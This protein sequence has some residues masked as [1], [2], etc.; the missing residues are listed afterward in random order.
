MK[1]IITT[2]LLSLAL[3][4]SAQSQTALKSWWSL[5]YCTSYSNQNVRAFDSLIGTNGA[6]YFVW[7]KIANN[8][9]IAD[10]PGIQIKP[11]GTTKGYWKRSYDG[12][13]HLDWMG[14]SNSSTQLTWTQLGYR[15]SKLDSMY[16]GFSPFYIDST[17]RPD[18]TALILAYSAMETSGYNFMEMSPR[19]YYI[20]KDISSSRTLGGSGLADK[21]QFGIAGKC[22]VVHLKTNEACFLDRVPGSQSIA[23]DQW[24]GAA[25]IISDLI[26]DGGGFNTT[27][28]RLGATSNSMIS[29]VTFKNCY[30]GLDARFCLQMQTFQTEGNNCAYIDMLFS[31]GNWPD[32]SRSNSQSNRVRVNGHRTFG[33][34]GWCGVLFQ[35]GSNCSVVDMVIE[36]GG[37][38]WGVL[39]DCRAGGGSSI[40]KE[41]LVDNIYGEGDYDSAAV[42]IMNGDG[43]YTV[44]R[45]FVRGT[46]NIVWAEDPANQYP[47]INL[48]EVV[49]FDNTMNLVQIGNGWCWDVRNFNYAGTNTQTDFCCNN[50]I[51]N[52]GPGGSQ[53]PPAARVRIAPK[54]IN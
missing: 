31:Y 2:L 28:I 48:Y 9:G 11:R 34:G 37:A 35:Q 49:W 22:A 52:T 17:F 42:G 39:F 1:K 10:I 6:G 54:I 19:N 51:F 4:F 44:Q 41:F 43:V 30:I 24:I 32:A 26:I 29:N 8:A 16:Q 25:F 15:Q 20:W 27:G 53:N 33:G 46:Q 13:I 23:N 45:V 18:E 40:C 12:P 21:Y 36:G 3:C 47:Q 38:N 50:G 7:Y 5:K 14:G